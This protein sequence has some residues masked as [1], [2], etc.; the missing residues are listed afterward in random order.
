MIVKIDQIKIF[1][2]HYKKLTNRKCNLTKMLCDIGLNAEWIEVF[3]AEELTQNDISHYYKNSN[4][5]WNEKVHWVCNSPFRKIKMSELS[6]SIK[7][8]LAY[9]K[10]IKE[11][12]DIALILEDDIV[13]ESNF[14]LLFDSYFINTPDDLDFAFI[15]NGC[16]L[17]I[18]ELKDKQHLYIKDNP[19]TKCTDSYLITN[20]AAKKI[21]SD[22]IP[23]T[24]PIDFELNFSIKK[25]RLK[26]YWLEPPLISQ[27]SQT[28][29]YRSAIQ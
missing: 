8:I 6:L 18:E 20:S 13:F 1:V 12:Y 29:L 25:H 21:M 10:I 2:M 3:D 27:G 15:G 7:H 17:K 4:E 11:N 24:V 16:G 22:L 14:K 9:E 26:T 19:A 5:V 23:I 28:G